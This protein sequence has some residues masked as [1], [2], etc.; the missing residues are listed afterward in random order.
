[1]LAVTKSWQLA[2]LVKLKKLSESVRA[3]VFP[4]CRKKLQHWRR[5]ASSSLTSHR[6]TCNISSTTTSDFSEA[7]TGFASFRECNL[8]SGVRKLNKFCFAKGLP[9]FTRFSSSDNAC[10][11]H[12]LP[13]RQYSTIHF[14]CFTEVGLSKPC[15]LKLVSLVNF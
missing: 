12:Y 10:C 13:I 8:H 6:Q 7:V 4:A 1:M 14:C 2:M 9:T 5:L 3:C 11:H 15:N